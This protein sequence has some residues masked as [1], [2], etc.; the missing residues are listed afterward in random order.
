MAASLSRSAYCSNYPN[1]TH[2]VC[3]YLQSLFD[4][5]IDIRVNDSNTG[6]SGLLGSTLEYQM[7]L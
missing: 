1:K 6:V 4:V 2:C 7:I 3:A 5:S